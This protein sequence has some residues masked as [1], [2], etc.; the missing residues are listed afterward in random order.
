MMAP[1]R[2]T[3]SRPVRSGWKPAATSISAPTRPRTSQWPRVGRRIRVSSFSVVDLPAPFG[4]MMPSASPGV[5]LERHV[6]ERPEL[7]RRQARRPSA[8]GQPAK[9]STGSGRAGCRAARRG[10]TSSRP[11]R[12]RLACAISTFSA[13]RIRLD[14]RSSTRRRA[15]PPTSAAAPQKRGRERRLIPQ[16][17]GAVASM[18]GV[19]GLRPQQ[20]TQASAD[21]LE[22][23]RP[24]TSRTSRP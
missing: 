13:N 23:D 16:Q 17:H 3:F 2:K 4:P 19:I 22:R 7:L 10:G 12:R 14:G 11:D 21:E 1:C 6:L 24:P 18:M 20:R 5:H 15:G 9:R 8:A